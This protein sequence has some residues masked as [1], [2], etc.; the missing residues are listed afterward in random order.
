MDNFT[1]EKP[2]R[3][4]IEKLDFSKVQQEEKGFTTHLNIVLQNIHDA[5]ALG[6]WCYLSSLPT[7]WKINKTHLKNHFKIGRDKLNNALS[8]LKKLDLIQ[9]LQDRKPDGTLEESIILVKAGHDFNHNTD[10]QYSGE[11]SSKIKGS[12]RYTE[13]PATG[14]P[15]TGKRPLQKKEVKKKEKEQNKQKSFYVQNPKNENSKKHDFA[16]SMDQMASE[17]KHI[18]EHEERKRMEKATPM[19]DNIKQLLGLPKR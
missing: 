6:I 2:K 1:V 7:N 16:L 17:A 14:K 18:T 15:V 10:F 13:K 4:N 11:E 19:P 5:F 8:I 12:N 3:N 9:F